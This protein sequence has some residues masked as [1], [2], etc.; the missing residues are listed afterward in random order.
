MKKT[1]G[2]LAITLFIAIGVT[3]YAFIADRGEVRPQETME[4]N[5]EVSKLIVRDLENDYP[6]SPREVVRF[7]SRIM[8][9]Y[10]LL[11]YT[12]EELLQLVSQSRILFDSELVAENSEEEYIADLK[13]EINSYKEK[14]QTITGYSVAQVSEVVYYTSEGVDYANVSAVYNLKNKNGRTKV[15][16]D[17]MLRKD[18]NDSWKILGWQLTPESEIEND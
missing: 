17:Y 11:D 8:E 5:D 14:E 3:Y 18:E 13:A 12:E 6:N 4:T 2:I 10:Y 9:S 1:R 16:E 7:Y 15:Y